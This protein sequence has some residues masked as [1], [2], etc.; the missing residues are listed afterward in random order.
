[1]EK[2]PVYNCGRCP[3]KIAT[4]FYST[5]GW[6]RMEDWECT[7]ADNKKIRGAVEWHEES[8]I[9]IPEWCPYNLGKI[10]EIKSDMKKEYNMGG[11][12]FIMTVHLNSKIEKTINGKR[13][14]TILTKG[15]DNEY[16]KTSIVEDSLLVPM[17][18]SEEKAMNEWAIN[19]LSNTK[20]QRLIDLGFE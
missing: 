1:M 11:L 7:A 17:I 18:E 10:N 2:K 16:I 13:Y 15:I 4:N 8:K 9:P 3:N 19:K 5:D 14:H 12:K 20:D 6:D